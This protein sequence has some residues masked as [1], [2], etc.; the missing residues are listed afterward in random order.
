LELGGHFDKLVEQG[1]IVKSGRS[2]AL[3]TA[4]PQG[5]CEATGPSD[6]SSS[7]CT[8]AIF[9]HLGQGM[10]NKVEISQA[11][12]AELEMYARDVASDFETLVLSGS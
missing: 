4:E 12:A 8:D 6:L 9:R 3:P 2:F 7:R 11:V 10:T 5:D 1:K